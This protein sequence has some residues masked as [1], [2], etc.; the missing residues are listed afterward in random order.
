M[1]NRRGHMSTPT[2]RVE[3]VAHQVVQAV[4]SPCIHSPIHESL[5]VIVATVLSVAIAAVVTVFVAV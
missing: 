5:V 4:H 1:D 2:H 3:T